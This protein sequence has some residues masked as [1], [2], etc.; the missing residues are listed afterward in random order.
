MKNKKIIIILLII[1][2]ISIVIF[3]NNINKNRNIISEKQIIKEMT[4]VEY[5]SKI[6]ELSKS[7]ENYA[8]QVQTNK[9]KIANAITEMGVETSEEDTLETMVSNIKSIS[10][11]SQVNVKYIPNQTYSSKYGNYI[12]DVDISEYES[13]FIFSRVKNYANECA[14]RYLYDNETLSSTE[15]I[16]DVSAY[17][18]LKVEVYTA[19]DY[20]PPKGIVHVILVFDGKIEYM[21]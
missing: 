3:C 6:T 20:A 12:I 10:N 8:L 11:S 2:I 19:N 5:E 7:H 1:N 14:V 15:G 4:E 13:I 21:D 9:E 18:N 17:S 16:I